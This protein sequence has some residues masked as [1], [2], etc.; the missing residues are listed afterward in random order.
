MLIRKE[1]R[2]EC[3][4]RMLLKPCQSRIQGHHILTIKLFKNT[5]Q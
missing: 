1:S 3:Y 2:G 4:P 5:L